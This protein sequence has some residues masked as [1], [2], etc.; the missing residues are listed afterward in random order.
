MFNIRL[1]DSYEISNPFLVGELPA[2][3]LCAT[4]AGA[5]VGKK[6]RGG[7]VVLCERRFNMCGISES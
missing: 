3:A 5:K 7:S 4:I 1:A 2:T 6:I